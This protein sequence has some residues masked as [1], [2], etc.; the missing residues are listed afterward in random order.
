MVGPAASRL[1]DG[2]LERGRE[3]PRR[4]GGRRQ[5]TDATPGLGAI[6]AAAQR[7]VGPRR[8]RRQAGHHVLGGRQRALHGAWGTR[9]PTSDH[10]CGYDGWPSR[11]CRRHADHPRAVA[12]PTAAAQPPSGGDP[13]T[14]MRHSWSAVHATTAWHGWAPQDPMTH[15]RRTRDQE[16]G[17]LRRDRWGTAAGHVPDGAPASQADTRHGWPEPCGHQ[18]SHAR[19]GMA[20]RA[21]AASMVPEPRG[22][23]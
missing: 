7:S 8:A 3:R 6:R 17:E 23:P 12:S 1:R 10:P 14:W 13:V 18:R 21:L 4:P 19:R 22:G 9:S 2:L 15:G 16:R 5:R 11:R 20:T